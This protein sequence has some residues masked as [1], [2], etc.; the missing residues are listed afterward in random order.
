[1][2]GRPTSFTVFAKDLLKEEGEPKY[3][4]LMAMLSPDLSGQFIEWAFDHVDRDDVVPDNGK[5]GYED[6]PHITIL[7]GFHEGV[8]HEEVL[9]AIKDFGPITLTLGKIS[10]FKQEELD[11]LKID[12]ESKDLHESNELLREKFAERLTVKFPDYHPHQTIAYVKKGAAEDIDPETF[13]GFEMTITDLMY[14]YP[15]G[16][17]KVRLKLEEREEQVNE[18]AL[19]TTPNIK[20]QTNPFSAE[21]ANIPARYYITYSTENSD[22]FKR[23]DS[24]HEKYK[25]LEN[26]IHNWVHRY[27][28]WSFA[29]FDNALQGCM[30]VIRN[31]LPGF[32]NGEKMYNHVDELG[33]HG[34]GIFQGQE[35]VI[36][37][38]VKT[39][40]EGIDDGEIDTDP[41]DDIDP[42]EIL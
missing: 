1:M 31:I 24:E 39:V 27:D 14:S 13:E 41:N 38:F 2:I 40:Q 16:V 10:K 12:V 18:I 30:M 28:M 3:G 29:E 37:M 9:N 19:N 36:W 22:L 23:L 7:Y 42:D 32:T 17:K 25:N 20:K 34:F 33:H 4:C 15:D 6:E 21:D 35:I 26:L 8:T 11:V 5:T